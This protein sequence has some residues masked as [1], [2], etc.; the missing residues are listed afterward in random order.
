MGNHQ[1][2]A[3]AMTFLDFIQY[4]QSA[5]GDINAALPARGRI[6]SGIGQPAQLVVGKLLPR[7]RER[8]A[9]PFTEIQFT[10]AVA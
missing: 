9:L 5:S 4:S 10:Q 2:I 6:P 7:L 3:L 1:H 8:P